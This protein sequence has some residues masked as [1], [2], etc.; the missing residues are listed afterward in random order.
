[1]QADV[2]Q[3]LVLKQALNDF[4]KS[5]RLFVNFHKSCMLPINITNEQVQHPAH[6]FG[7]TVGTMPFTYLGLPLGTTRPKFKICCLWWI[8]WREDWC[9]LPPFWHME[10]DCSLLDHV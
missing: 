8:G 3:L 4:P 10:G 5:T 6:E 9:L 7:C 1:M 2:N